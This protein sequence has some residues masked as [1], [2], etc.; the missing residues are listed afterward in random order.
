MGG[1]I[2]VTADFAATVADDLVVVG[3]GLP[4]DGNNAPNESFRLEQ[5][6][7]ATEAL[8]GGFAGY[9]RRAAWGRS[10][11]GQGGWLTGKEKDPKWT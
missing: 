6:H 4:D 10:R 3:F 7:G 5:F 11:L 9:G 1:S 2:P 8:L